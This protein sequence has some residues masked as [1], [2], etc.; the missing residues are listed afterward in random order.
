MATLMMIA[1][2][3]TGVMAGIYFAF[4]VFIMKAL[5]QLPAAEGAR[6]MNRINDVIVRTLFLPLFLG[7]TVLA[8]ALILWQLFEGQSVQSSLQVTAGFIYLVGM[9]GVTVACNVP[10]N[11]RLKQHEAD[12][13][14]LVE[15]WAEYLHRWIRLNHVRTFSCILSLVLLALSMS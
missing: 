14:A 6:A 8:I 15:F 9:F 1:L 7:S 12:E 4:S 11:N 13:Q 2:V 10:L 5:A 3:M